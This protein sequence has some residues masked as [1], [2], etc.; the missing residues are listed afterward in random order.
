[1]SE[2]FAGQRTRDVFL[3]AGI[4]LFGSPS[5]MHPAP[6]QAYMDREQQC[7]NT[8]SS[9]RPHE[10]LWVDGLAQL[11]VH[12]PAAGTALARMLGGQSRQKTLSVL[13]SK[14]DDWC[15]ICASETDRCARG[16]IA[17]EQLGTFCSHLSGSA[18]GLTVLAA[19]Y[20]DDETMMRQLAAMQTRINRQVRSTTE[21]LS[22]HARR[23]EEEKLLEKAIEPTIG[24]ADGDGGAA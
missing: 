15:G 5:K 3:G 6:L 10:K 7:M 18:A 12:E 11:S 8:L 13:R 23:N 1:M 24:R 4:S 21:A 22:L 19:T 17:V 16:A 9:L 14:V 20:K 2:F